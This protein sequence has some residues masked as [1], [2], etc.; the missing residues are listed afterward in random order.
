MR[1]RSFTAP[2]AREA[3]LRARAELGDQARIITTRATSRGIELVVA[4]PQARSSQ[5]DSAA[6]REELQILRE[7]MASFEPRVAPGLE[8]LDARLRAAGC[9]GALR[10]RALAAAAPHRGVAAV[11]A[12]SST[13]SQLIP[14]LPP[15]PI[16]PDG[17]RIVAMVGPTGS[18]KT[19]TIAKLAARLVHQGGRRVGLITLD[20][21]RVGAT[22]QIKAYANWLQAPVATPENPAAFVRDISQFHDCDVILIDT[23]GRSPRDAA[24]LAELSQT[25]S[26][27]DRLE[28]LLVLSANHSIASLRLACSQF[29][30]TRPSGCVITKLDETG[31]VAPPFCV[32]FEQN[33]PVAFLCAGQEVPGDLERATGARSAHFILKAAAVEA[34][35]GV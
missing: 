5:N 24:S 20:S 33:L 8:D 31:H 29:S 35:A 12:A 17:P 9:T 21:Y 27:V 26:L 6:L 7:R 10:D 16:H 1:V 11:D 19:T 32:A 4:E 30:A 3:L 28:T 22:E 14:I 34:A 15:R 23:T 2:S 25:L 18:G 13:I